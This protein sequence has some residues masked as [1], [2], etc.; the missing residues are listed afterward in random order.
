MLSQ[1][2]GRTMLIPR[3]MMPL[4]VSFLLKGWGLMVETLLMGR[5]LMPVC[6][7][8]ALM[9]RIEGLHGSVAALVGHE[10]THDYGDGTEIQGSLVFVDQ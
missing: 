6:H 2:D 7:L 5:P 9:R 8:M 10:D 1:E 4:G 3:S